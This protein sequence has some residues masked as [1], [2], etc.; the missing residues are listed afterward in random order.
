[1]KWLVGLLLRRCWFLWPCVSSKLLAFEKHLEDHEVA[2][3]ELE[4]QVAVLE[5]GENFKQLSDLVNKAQALECE[6]QVAVEKLEAH[7]RRLSDRV[8]EPAGHAFGGVEQWHHY[9]SQR[10]GG[11][12]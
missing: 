2:V 11:S 7:F 4:K 3:L 5:L 12:R 8:N 1:M 9:D 6:R 10:C